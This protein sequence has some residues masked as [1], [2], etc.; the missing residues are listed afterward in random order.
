MHRYVKYLWKASLDGNSN[1]S[2]DNVKMKFLFCILLIASVV[3]CVSDTNATNG[4]D[5]AATTAAATTTT[6]STSSDNNN[7]SSTNT[8]DAIKPSSPSNE[9]TEATTTSSASAISMTQC[10]LQACLLAVLVKL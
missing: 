2:E 8:T 4:T 5:N 6:T 10:F 9:T 1:R 7:G 3:F